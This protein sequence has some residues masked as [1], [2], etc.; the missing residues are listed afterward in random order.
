LQL[1]TIIADHCAFLLSRLA[2]SLLFAGAAE[3]VRSVMGGHLHSPRDSSE[4]RMLYCTSVLSSSMHIAAAVIASSSAVRAKPAA[5][6]RLQ[7]NRPKAVCSFGMVLLCLE[8]QHMH[9]CHCSVTSAASGGI[10]P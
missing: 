1:L 10:V 5:F 3:H 9:I 8:F 4:Q 2:F 7:Q 6:C